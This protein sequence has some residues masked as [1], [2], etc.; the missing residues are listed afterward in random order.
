MSLQNQERDDPQSYHQIGNF[1]LIWKLSWIASIMFGILSVLFFFSDI[2]IFGIFFTMFLLALFG[3]FYLKTFKKDKPVYWIYIVVS[4]VL[5]IASFHGLPYILH[6]PEII[7][8]TCVIGLAFIGLKFRHALIL[9]I[10]HIVSFVLFILTGLNHNLNSIKPLSKYDVLAMSTQSVLGLTLILILFQQ[11]R[12]YGKITWKALKKEKNRYKLI[13]DNI[14]EALIQDD[15]AGKI[16]FYNPKFLLMFGFEKEDL[17]NLHITDLIDPEYHEKIIYNHTKRINGDFLTDQFEC[18]GVRKDGTKIWLRINAIPIVDKSK[19]IGTQSLIIDISE[20]KNHELLLEEMNHELIKIEELERERIAY[21]LHDG[22]NQMLIT[23]KLYAEMSSADEHLIEILNNTINESR[24]ITQNLV[25]KE[26]HELGIVCSLELL[27]QKIILSSKISIEFTSID[28]ACFNFMP[29]HFKFNL[30]RI[31]QEC[32]NNTIKHS[33]AE[34]VK[35]NISIE[36]DLLIILF[37]N[38]GLFIPKVKIEDKYFLI[39]I[40]RRLKILS[41][42]YKINYNEDG[43]VEFQFTFPL[44]VNYS[45]QRA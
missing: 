29:E 27:V 26:I 45:L 8:M 13:L 14:N 11:Y 25:P 38:N 7:W 19:I 35:I 5:L 33:S 6:Y 22:L 40:R 17:T 9:T 42:S 37:F 15:V 12:K 16:I 31:I 20:R 4:S 30:F 24:S 34:K 2:I 10:I 32:F 39:A 36:N 23:A 18:S 3:L 43:K 44:S 28:E 41:G 1:N 21:E